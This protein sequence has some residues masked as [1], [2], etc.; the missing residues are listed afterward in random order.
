M[1]MRVVDFKKLIKEIPFE[2][3]SFDIRKDLWKNEIHQKFINEVILKRPITTINRK[4]LYDPQLNIKQFI[5]KTLMWGYPTK[6]R[7]K[8]IDNLL[9]TDNLNKLVRI[10]QEY[11]N[12]EIT[13][14]ELKDSLKISG[15][16]LSTLT[17][18]THFLNTKIN[19]NRAVM[20]DLQII[21]TINAN[22]FEE[23]N[24]LKNINYE[25]AINFY[26]E[27]IGLINSLANKMKVIEDQV[28][29]FLF[30]FGRKLSK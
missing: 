23:F 21:N 14:D 9:K 30:I 1:N 13:I 3:H 29:M 18:F 8:N 7:G 22:R 26:E 27:Y 24:S 4:D 2:N 28:E 25:N 5:F 16:G 6:G 17:K 11:R 19:G 12:N 15:L 20:L 10:L